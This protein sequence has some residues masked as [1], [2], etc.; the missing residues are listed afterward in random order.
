MGQRVGQGAATL[1]TESLIP[2][3][4]METTEYRGDD[5]AHV[6]GGGGGQ[7]CHGDVFVLG[8]TAD[9]WWDTRQ[10]ATGRP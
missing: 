2:K 6:E 4:V 1:S 3:N 9:R 8:P 10:R 5:D 7:N